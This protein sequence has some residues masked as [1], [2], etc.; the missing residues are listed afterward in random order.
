MVSSFEERLNQLH[1]IALQT[2]WHSPVNAAIEELTKLLLLQ[3]VAS[4]IPLFTSLRAFPLPGDQPQSGSRNAT[5]SKAPRAAFSAVISHPDVVASR[6]RVAQ[7]QP[8][9][10]L[11]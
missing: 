6:A 1:E 11:R 10:A 5:M 7:R 9:M 3:V 4:G 2:W 8:L